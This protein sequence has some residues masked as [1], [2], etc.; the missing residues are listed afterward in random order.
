M[1]LTTKNLHYFKTLPNILPN[2][3]P[4]Y[5]LSQEQRSI[6]ER[7]DALHS[8]VPHLP[9][10]TPHRIVSNA[11]GYGEMGIHNALQRSDFDQPY[12]WATEFE[13]VHSTWNFDEPQIIVDGIQYEGSEDYYHSQKPF[14]FDSQ[15]W[16]HQRDEVMKTAVY[17]KFT[18]SILLQNLLLS[19]Q[20]HPLLSIKRDRYWGVLPSGE[21]ENKLAVLLMEL[22][23]TLKKSK[24]QH[25][26]SVAV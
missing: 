23:T 10:W 19:T 6:C 25:Q 9:C 3:E 22:R 8:Y 13:N 5:Y 7:L 15:L 1:P 21:G 24:S 20:N 14:P 17:H 26:R 2:N 11:L 16:H 18:T 12:V 4:Y